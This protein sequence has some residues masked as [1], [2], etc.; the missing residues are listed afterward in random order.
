ML[1]SQ[2]F[3]VR[4]SKDVQARSADA[5]SKTNGRVAT[6]IIVLIGVVL[7]MLFEPVIRHHPE[8][9]VAEKVQFP[10]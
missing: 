1:K 6:A 3:G 4:R 9:T 5:L 2:V 10:S 7:A 8:R